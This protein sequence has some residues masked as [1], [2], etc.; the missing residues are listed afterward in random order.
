MHT[1]TKTHQLKITHGTSRARDTEGYPTVTLTDEQG[2]RFKCMGGGY[3]MFGTV[4]AQ[5][6]TATYPERTAELAPR[7][8]YEFRE[9]S[10]TIVHKDGRYGVYHDATEGRVWIDGAVGESTVQRLARDHFGLTVRNLTNGKG[11]TIGYAVEE[12]DTDE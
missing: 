11:H 12:G 2:R 8:Y 4:L 10:G 3:D 5:W 9:G 6:L 1:M 7:A